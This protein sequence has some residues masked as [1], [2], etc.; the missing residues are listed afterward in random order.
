LD[1]DLDVVPKQRRRSLLDRVKSLYAKDPLCT[2]TKAIQEHGLVMRHGVWWR[3]G[4]VY[5]P[6]S[7]AL[8]D[9]ILTEMHDSSAADHVGVTKTLPCGRVWMSRLTGRAVMEHHGCIGISLI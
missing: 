8:R 1:S 7:E 3:S 6:V 5:V 4:Q 9:V 2:D